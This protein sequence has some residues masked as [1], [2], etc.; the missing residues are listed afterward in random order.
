MIKVENLVKTY[1]GYTALNGI[2]FEVKKGEIV[3]FL[4]P[5]GAGKTTTMRILS[6]Y[7]PP[8]SG[9][10]EVAGYD[11]LQK[12]LEIKKRVGYMPENVPLYTDLRV[13]EYLKYRAKLKGIR[14][15]ELT[16]RVQSVLKLCH[17]EEVASSIIGNLSKG[18]RQR[19]GLADALIHDP[20]LLILDEPTIGLDPNQIRSV[21]ELIRN[22]GQRHTI[23]L[24]SHI[25]S[26]V[27]AVCTRVLIINKGKI[28]AA[29]TPENLSKLVR[30]G[31]VGAL[32][33]E[34]LC[35]PSIAKEEFE[36][37]GDVDEVEILEEYPDGWIVIQLWP[38]L[39][40][41]IRDKVYNV[42][43]KK[44]WKLREMSRVKATLEDIFVE[45]TQ[46]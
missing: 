17:I 13:I 27:E 8:T 23:I 12:P 9:K 26:E 10:V 43:Q 46:D 5:N 18:Y 38:K 6:C 22:L 37:I 29:D 19:V 36:L 34:I 45:L 20:D 25:L 30:G 35:K 32:R 14:G 33:L 24:S 44:G 40:S 41:D 39:G 4:G 28:E 1:S 7:L 15:K 21:R 2:S 42:I 11:V 31:S 16:E 3:G